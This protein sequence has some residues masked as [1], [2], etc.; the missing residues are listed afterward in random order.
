M[1]IT[2]ILPILEKGL[3]L[4]PIIIQAGEDVAPAIKVMYNLVIGAQ[5][6]TITDVELT[7]AEVKLDQMISDFN[8]PMP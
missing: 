3:Q 4:L 8:E 2:T 6:G 1:D 5:A 7:D